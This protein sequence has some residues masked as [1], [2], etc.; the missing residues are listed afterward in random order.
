MGK[1]IEVKD[2]T[3]HYPDQKEPLFDQ[4]SLSIERGQWVAI[5]GHNGSGKSTLVRIIDGLLAPQAGTIFV[6][7][8]PVTPENIWQIREKIGMVVQNPD[9]QFV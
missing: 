9:N 4:L 1:I 3:F 6:D 2:L 7:G 8:M 5:I